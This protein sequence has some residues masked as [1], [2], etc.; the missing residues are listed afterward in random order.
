MTLEGLKIIDKNNGFTCFP[1][2]MKC[3]YNVYIDH[4]ALNVQPS[5]IRYNT[6]MSVFLQDLS[7]YYHYISLNL[8]WCC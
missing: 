7:S 8:H 1:N 5:F 4:L 6:M 2:C 3:C